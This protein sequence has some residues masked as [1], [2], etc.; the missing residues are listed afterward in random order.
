MQGARP[1]GHCQPTGSIV[2]AWESGQAARIA[3][4]VCIIQWK[5]LID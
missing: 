4:S 3:K 2:V 5:N 1:I